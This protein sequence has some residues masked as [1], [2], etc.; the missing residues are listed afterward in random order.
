VLAVEPPEVEGLKPLEVLVRTEPAVTDVAGL[1]ASSAASRYSDGTHASALAGST[2][3]PALGSP[4]FA[5]APPVAPG[6]YTDSILPGETLLYRVPEVG[7][8]QQPVCDFG[9]GAS[10]SAR[11]AL[12]DAGYAEVATA[13]V[14]G[15]MKAQVTDSAA[16]ANRVR[17]D[18]S[19]RPTVHVAGPRVAYQNRTAN[20]DRLTDAALAGDYYCALTL[21]T[22]T[23]LVDA[24]VGEVPVTLDVAV[25]GDRS[26]VPAYAADPKK[27]PDERDGAAGEHGSGGWPWIAGGVLALAAVALG[28]VAIRGRRRR[29]A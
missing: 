8:G 4:S 29:R 14:Y 26:G 2:A 27:G 7:W 11:A 20:D 10:P 1:P 12:A 28:S 22:S 25:V 6:R 13:R 24:K 3:R 15:P 18:G 19:G 17:Y 5:G 16:S 21:F 23:P 9:L